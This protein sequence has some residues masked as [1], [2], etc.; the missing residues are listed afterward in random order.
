MVV[1]PKLSFIAI[2]FPLNEVMAN[3]EK[4]GVEQTCRMINQ[5]III[6]VEKIKRDHPGLDE[7]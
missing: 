4:L 6:A 5:T 2:W 7:N 1:V 3:L